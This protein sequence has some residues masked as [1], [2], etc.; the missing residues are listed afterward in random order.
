MLHKSANCIQASYCKPLNAL[1]QRQEVIYRLWSYHMRPGH[2]ITKEI[3]SLKE[4]TIFGHGRALPRENS[5]VIVSLIWR[6]ALLRFHPFTRSVWR[7]PLAVLCREKN[8]PVLSHGPRKGFS[9]IIWRK[10]ELHRPDSS[11][12]SLVLPSVT[13]NFHLWAEY[14]WPWCILGEELRIEHDGSMNGQVWELMA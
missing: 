7:S 8:V 5:F 9:S 11:V 3:A 1:S 14:G 6:Q 4:H 10:N 13:L 2:V 12:I